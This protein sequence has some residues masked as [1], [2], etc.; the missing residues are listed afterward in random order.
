[1]SHE[2]TGGNLGTFGA[3]AERAISHKTFGYPG[4]QINVVGCG[5]KNQPSDEERGQQL[6]TVSSLWYPAWAGE[7]PHFTS[8]RTRDQGSA[9]LACTMTGN[10]PPPPHTPLLNVYLKKTGAPFIAYSTW[11]IVRSI[12]IYVSHRFVIPASTRRSMQS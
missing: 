12:Y 6:R 2:C 1:M 3:F 7:N 4:Y 11:Y 8:F 9:G 5:Y 10:P